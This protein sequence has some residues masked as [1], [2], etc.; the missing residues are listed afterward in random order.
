MIWIRLSWLT[1]SS[2][3]ATQRA[4]KTSKT[5]E[6]RAMGEK[7]QESLV[8]VNVVV[9][10]CPGCFF[11]ADQVVAALPKRFRELTQRHPCG[12][13]PPQTPFGNSIYLCRLDAD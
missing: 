12:Y 5:L 9:I 4:G 3:L 1:M 6:R 11:F 8:A 7:Y 13:F 2:A 10:V